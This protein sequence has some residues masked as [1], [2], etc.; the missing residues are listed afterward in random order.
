[1]QY[2]WVLCSRYLS[3][4]FY[5]NLIGISVDISASSGPTI[6]ICLLSWNFI[7]E[8]FDKVDWDEISRWIEDTPDE[9]GINPE[10]AALK[11]IEAG[12][13]G[14]PTVCTPNSDTKRFL[15]AGAVIAENEGEWLHQLEALSDP[16]VYAQITKDIE[17]HL[18][19]LADVKKVA[20]LFLDYIAKQTTDKQ[21]YLYS[22]PLFPMKIAKTRRKQGLYDCKTLWFYKKAWQKKKQCE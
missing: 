16:K 17:T 9:L 12:Y 1:M 15:H 7:K 19:E 2:F 8:F 13:W 10:G 3:P 4:Y 6:I 5:K 18:V 11:V 20:Q 21:K 22:K 14:I